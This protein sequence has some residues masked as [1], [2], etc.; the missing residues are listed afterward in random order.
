M[1]KKGGYKILNLHGINL[2]SGKAVTMVGAYDALEHNY[3][4]V[5]LLSGLVVSG[6][7]YADFFTLF[8]HAGNA[9]TAV[10]PEIGTISVDSS[11]KVT[12]TTKPAAA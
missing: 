9:F 2:T 5:I 1:S 6:K 7:E 11:D 12:F 10:I 3:H 4:K 8:T